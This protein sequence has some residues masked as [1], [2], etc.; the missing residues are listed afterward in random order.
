M[1]PIG[2]ARVQLL[3]VEEVVG[4]DDQTQRCGSRQRHTLRQTRDTS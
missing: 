1:D 3:I 4:E 2:L